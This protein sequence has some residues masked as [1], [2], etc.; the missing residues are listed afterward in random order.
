M[1]KR[2]IFAEKLR[3]CGNLNMSKNSYQSLVVP[4]PG[5]EPGWCEPADFK[6][7]RKHIFINILGLYFFRKIKSYPQAMRLIFNNAKTFCGTVFVTQQAAGR[8]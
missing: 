3:N 1:R 2:I 5:L 4:A 6:S 8:V 7:K